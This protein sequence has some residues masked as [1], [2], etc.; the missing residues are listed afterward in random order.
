MNHAAHFV[1][2]FEADDRL[3]RGVSRF[4]GEGLESNCTCISIATPEHRAKI[5]EQLRVRGLDP[6]ALET[7]YRYIN[8]DARDQL[9]KLSVDGRSDQQRFHDVMGLLIRQ[10]GARGQPVRVFGEM[11]ALLAAEGRRDA[12][13]RVEE[14][15]NELSRHYSFTLFCAYPLTAFGGDLRSQTLVCAIHGHVVPTE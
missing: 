2:F 14:L 8:L 4:I 1:Q 9:T 15:W 6:A 13:I 5:A 11:V 7:E 10:A 3:V 12:V